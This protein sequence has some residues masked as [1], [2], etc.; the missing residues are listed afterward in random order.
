MG[1]T[2]IRT[3]GGLVHRDLSGQ[4]IGR[5]I[6]WTQYAINIFIYSLGSKEFRLAYLDFIKLPCDRS[7]RNR[8]EDESRNNDMAMTNV[9]ST[10]LDSEHQT[11]K[12]YI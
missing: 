12:L 6:N 11:E 7:A 5:C 10:H 1:A 3:A 2:A 9:M 4:T 8:D